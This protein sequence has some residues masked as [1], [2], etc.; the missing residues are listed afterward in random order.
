M[1]IVGFLQNL[2]VK[3]PEKVVRMFSRDPRPDYR[4]DLLRRFLFY[5]SRSGKVLQ[6][7]FG[8]ELCARIV[9]EES[10][11]EISGNSRGPCGRPPS[12][13]VG[14]ITEVLTRHRPDM[15][16]AFGSIAA[17]GCM[18]ALM[19]MT[20]AGERERFQAELIAGPHPA[21]IGKE[22]LRRLNE[23]RVRI[24]ALRPANTP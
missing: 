17:N 14:H 9:W 22:P 18:K 10:T 12:P 8:K 11:R 4:E 6:A 23:M 16:L 21:A 20:F 19:G 15:V 13:D 7:V 5:K 1:K 24:E 2:W 3:N